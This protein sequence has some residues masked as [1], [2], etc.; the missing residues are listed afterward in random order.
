MSDS[1]GTSHHKGG[2]NTV[3]SH[4]MSRRKRRK[5]ISDLGTRVVFEKATKPL[6]EETFYWSA[7]ADTCEKVCKDQ[8]MQTRGF[9][10]FRDHWRFFSGKVMILV[11]TVRIWVR[12]KRQQ[13]IHLWCW[14]K[15][16]RERHEPD[17]KCCDLGLMW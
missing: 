6:W 12:I 3:S 8:K 15:L 11:R 7:K 13:L 16:E 9:M 17:C 4:W 5:G 14:E 2:K 1:T 10:G